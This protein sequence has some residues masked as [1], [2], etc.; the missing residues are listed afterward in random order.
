MEAFSDL[1]GCPSI[2]ERHQSNQLKE[3]VENLNSKSHAGPTTRARLESLVGKSQ[4]WRVDF[5]SMRLTKRYKLSRFAPLIE[6]WRKNDV[7]LISPPARHAYH[8]SI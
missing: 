2:M 6:F 7:K 4:T 8:Q 5:Y 3:L 1:V